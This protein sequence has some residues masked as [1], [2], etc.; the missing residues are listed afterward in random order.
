M[1]L[2][3]TIERWPLANPFTISRG[4]KTEAVV[5]TVELRDG[6]HC[7]HGECVPYARYGET[8]ERVVAAIEA[9]RP[10]LRR[11]LDRVALQAACRQVRR[12]THSIALFGIST[13]NK[14]AGG[15]TN[16]RDLRRRNRW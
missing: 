9:T 16:W 8:P 4:S 14:W 13:P 7:G 2:S 15:R 5:V 12:A 6:S 3:V 1:E 11:G 10:A